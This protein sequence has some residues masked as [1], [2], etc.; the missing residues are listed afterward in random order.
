MS[1]PQVSGEGSASVEMFAEGGS[2]EAFI[3]PREARGDNA[4]GEISG[5]GSDGKR[6][7]LVPAPGSDG[8]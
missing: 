7:L 6:T 4:I 2:V 8:M 5:C 3:F 1:W